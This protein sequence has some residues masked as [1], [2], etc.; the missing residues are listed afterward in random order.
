MKLLVENIRGIKRLEADV[1][2]LTLVVGRNNTGKTSI[3]FSLLLLH[4]IAGK[5]S[6]YFV[7]DEEST[8]YIIRRGTE[9][10]KV[11]YGNQSL[12]LSQKRDRALE[13]LEELSKIFKGQ[14]SE[15]KKLFDI[16][17][18][19]KFVV[20]ELEE[21]MKKSEGLILPFYRGGFFGAIFD[22]L[23]VI[24]Y[25]NYFYPCYCDEREELLEITDRAELVLQ[26]EEFIKKKNVLRGFERFVGLNIKIGPHL[27]PLSS[28]GD[29][30]KKLLRLM[31]FF[32]DKRDIYLLDEPTTFFHPGYVKLFVNV[33]A[34]EVKEGKK[35][36]IS[37]HSP[38]LT[39]EILERAEWDKELRDELTF[40]RTYG[41]PTASEGTVIT[42]EEAIEMKNVLLGDLRGV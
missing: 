38:D 16:I 2:R 20:Y 33:L 3:L 34:S 25:K 27:I 31:A 6:R 40:I 13:M 18:E 22:L 42:A 28:M 10:G 23:E 21:G 37:T 11:V 29:G 7:F 12:V 36:F 39:L 35:I 4:E 19:G 30:F 24:E 9:R 1:G 8:D 14:E 5:Q 26:L 17:N 41:D 32:S 15:R